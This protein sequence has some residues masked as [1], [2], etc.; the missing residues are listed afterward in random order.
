[1][2]ESSVRG[3][4]RFL[5]IELNEFNPDFLA[6]MAERMNLAYIREI[7][8]MQRAETSTADLVEHQGL[9]PW[10][11][12]V[13]VHCGKPTTEHGV[14]RLGATRTQDFP[15][16]W[17]QVAQHGFTWGVW[18]AMN[19]PL[20][21]PFGC[22]FF[23]PDPWSFDE[24]AYPS[25][26]N[27]LLALPR[28]VA[29]NYLEMD[30]KKPLLSALRLVRFFAPP[31]HWPLIADFATA[32][33]RAFA[34]TRPSV[35]TFSTLFDY[36]SVLCFVR[37]RQKSQSDFSLIFLNHIAHLQHHF[38]GAGDKQHP[39]MALGLRMNDAMF[40]LLLAGRSAGDALIVMNVLRQEYVGQK[41][42]YLYRQINTEATLQAIGVKAGR[43]E[44]CMT[45]DA[46]I[47]FGSASDADEA[48]AR[49]ERCRLSDGHAAFFV[50]RETP[51]QL[52]YQLAFVHQVTPAAQL[53]CGDR[54]LRF[55]DIFQLICERTG[56]HVPQGDVFYEGVSLPPRLANH[57][58]F[59]S[60]V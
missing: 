50:E 56:A 28:Y 2:R 24:Q 4:A 60:Q 44:Q 52:F 37:L 10:V 54:A 47:L 33:A 45:H 38:W 36:L 25:P 32:T 22:K 39:E 20:G 26:L 49:L 9:D 16:I 43:V 1:M 53:L 30:R 12:W 34:S 6:R 11:Q 15:Q 59:H 35:H 8:S 29:T 42:F 46:H 31:S 3:N 41:G 51:L 19:A 18:G 57:E 14:R 7:L 13:G 48:Q 40:G 17:H 21:N 55:Y 23:M 5:V 27:D 58:V